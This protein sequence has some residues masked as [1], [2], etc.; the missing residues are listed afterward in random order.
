ME[1]CG[2]PEHNRCR[3][4]NIDLEFVQTLIH[5]KQHREPEFRAIYPLGKIPVFTEEDLVIPESAAILTYLAETNPVADHWYPGLT[6]LMHRV[7]SHVSM[8][9]AINRSQSWPKV[10]VILCTSSKVLM[11]QFVASQPCYGQQNIPVLQAEAISYQLGDSIQV[12]AF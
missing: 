12:A 5:K 11:Q 8:G 2:M 4:T 10:I 3:A 9:A 7:H 6:Q 1:F